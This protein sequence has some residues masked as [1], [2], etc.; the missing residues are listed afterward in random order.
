MEGFGPGGAY[1]SRNVAFALYSLTLHRF[2]YQSVTLISADVLARL[3][4][5]GIMSVP[6][7]STLNTTHYVRTDTKRKNSAFYN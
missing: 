6:R 7:I 4:P 3:M 5:T 1:A 2:E